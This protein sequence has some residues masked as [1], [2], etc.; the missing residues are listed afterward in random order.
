MSLFRLII[1]SNKP[2]SAAKYYIKGESTFKDTKH[3]ITVKVNQG[4]CK[5][6]GQTLV[7]NLSHSLDTL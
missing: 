4:E 7:L 3:Q 2:C 6:E 5:Y 1:N